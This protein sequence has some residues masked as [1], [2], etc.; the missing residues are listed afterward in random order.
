MV[1]HAHTPCKGRAERRRFVM[2]ITARREIH[3]QLKAGAFRA[4][5]PQAAR[6]STCWASELGQGSRIPATSSSAT[7]VG[8]SNSCA[9]PLS[10][11]RPEILNSHS[12]ATLW[13]TLARPARLK[14]TA[15][16]LLRTARTQ[17]SMV[18]RRIA[19]PFRSK[20][21][22]LPPTESHSVIRR[23]TQT[24][25]SSLSWT[26]TAARAVRSTKAQSAMCV[27]SCPRSV[28]G[29]RSMSHY[30]SFAKL[31]SVSSMTNAFRCFV[32]IHLACGLCKAAARAAVSSPE[33]RRS[34][35]GCPLARA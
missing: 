8:G 29:D 3:N 7:F 5:H 2:R 21:R 17:V 18:V 22:V 26:S 24:T 25:C 19:R 11:Q 33:S 16:S 6:A 20:P 9:R 28:G 4:N 23:N 31:R 30:R 15:W 34:V 10:K 35:T 32:L 14:N 1:R 12:T 27:N 13:A